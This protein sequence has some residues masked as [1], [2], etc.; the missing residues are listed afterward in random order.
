M[1][2]LFLLATIATV[3]GSPHSTPAHPDFSGT[4]VLDVSKSEGNSLP[5][6]ATLKVT[7]SDKSMTLERTESQNGTTG[8]ITDTYMLDGSPSKNTRNAFG[9]TIDFNSTVAWSEEVLVITTR[10]TFDGRSFESTDLYS[11]SDDRKLLTIAKEAL[12]NGAPLTMR[13]VY[14]KQ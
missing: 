2:G 9:T 7:Q 1:R 14:T 10:W 4:W 6:S 12:I 11:L 13:Q 3:P 8:R 5:T